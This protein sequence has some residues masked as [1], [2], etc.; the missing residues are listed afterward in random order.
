MI[1]FLAPDSGA[2]QHRSGD[3][4]QLSA[5]RAHPIGQ[6]PVLQRLRQRGQRSVDACAERCIRVERL[7]EELRRDLRV[8][9]AFEAD[10]LV[11]DACAL[12]IAVA[13]PASSALAAATAWLH[14]AA[15]VAFGGRRATGG[16]APRAECGRMN[17]VVAPVSSSDEDDTVCTV[18]SI[19]RFGG[20][21][22]VYRGKNVVREIAA[23]K[24]INSKIQCEK[25]A[26][27]N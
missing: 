23:K 3:L 8:L 12:L 5:A 22:M 14:A 4:P 18:E 21:R 25:T 9:V 20:M 13:L 1:I 2:V 10:E 26:C 19:W 7:H 17:A 24:K 6:R 11:R 15:A 27:K 16:T